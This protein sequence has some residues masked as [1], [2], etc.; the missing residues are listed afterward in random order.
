[1]KDS[2]LY[3]NYDLSQEHMTK[4]KRKRRQIMCIDCSAW[5][6]GYC[7]IR[8]MLVDADTPVCNR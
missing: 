3:E 2:L 7:R 1:M 5:N 8:K 4:K 6:N